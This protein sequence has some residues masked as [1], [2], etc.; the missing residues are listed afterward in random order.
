MK[1]GGGGAARLCMYSTTCTRESVS[2]RLPYVGCARAFASCSWCRPPRLSVICVSV[3]C[4]I[5]YNTL[6]YAAADMSA[7]PGWTERTG[8]ALFFAINQAVE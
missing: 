1:G 6:L 2:V 3:F 8:G 4:F 5:G 7:S